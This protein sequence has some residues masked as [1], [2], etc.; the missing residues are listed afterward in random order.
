MTYALN[1]SA[2]SLADV[3]NEITQSWLCVSPMARLNWQID[4]LLLILYT[5]GYLV[6][7]YDGN[8]IRFE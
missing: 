8:D 7:I 4:I 5:F 2:K 6:D 1:F 3:L